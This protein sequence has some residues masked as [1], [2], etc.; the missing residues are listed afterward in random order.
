MS[1]L[2]RLYYFF[3]KFVC[4]ARENPIWSQYLKQAATSQR[5]D[6]AEDYLTLQQSCKQYRDLLQAYN[7]GEKRDT[8]KE[9]ENVARRVGLSMPEKQ[10][11]K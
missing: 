11:R 10:P 1:A 8:M 7:I 3:E 4:P 2:R 6:L 5:T 9:V